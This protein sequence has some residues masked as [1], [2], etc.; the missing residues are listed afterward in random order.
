M[1]MQ[2]KWHHCAEVLEKIY[3]RLNFTLSNLC[4]NIW[5]LQPIM[6]SC[7]LID[8]VMVVIYVWDMVASIYVAWTY[9]FMSIHT[10]QC[11]GTFNNT[12]ASL[13][14]LGQENI[15]AVAV[16]GQG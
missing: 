15:A 14:G 8:C 5:A 2:A 1:K 4:I 16:G 6:N 12:M 13:H 11:Q 7:T 3:I 9:Q 10:L